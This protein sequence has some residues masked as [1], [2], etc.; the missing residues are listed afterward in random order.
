MK[1]TVLTK[2]YEITDFAGIKG[3]NFYMSKIQVE[4]NNDK[5]ETILA[6]HLNT[7]SFFILKDEIDFQNLEG[8]FKYTDKRDP[9]LVK[10][11]LTIHKREDVEENKA[12]NNWIHL[13]FKD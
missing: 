11:F 1:I 9:D 7:K 5:Y 12:S 8:S 13:T 10:E 6:Y 3:E 4:N 2:P